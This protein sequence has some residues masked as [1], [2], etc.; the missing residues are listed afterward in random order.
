M[1]PAE[2]EAVA[3]RAASDVVKNVI[4]EEIH[5][6]F[7]LFGVDIKDQSSVN[8][9]RADL[10]CAREIREFKETTK[11][12]FWFVVIGVAVLATV[13]AFWEGIKVKMGW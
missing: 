4:H 11:K 7:R 10:I 9:L 3:R 13:S 1:T 2:I 12:R 8:R 6:V 5:D